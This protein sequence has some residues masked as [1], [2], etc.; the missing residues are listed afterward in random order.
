MRVDVRR[1][2]SPLLH[3]QGLADS[4]RSCCSFPSPLQPLRREVGGGP[5]KGASYVC[6]CTLDGV[7]MGMDMGMGVGS[8][9]VSCG[10][11]EFAKMPWCFCMSV[12]KATSRSQ[13]RVAPRDPS[14]KTLDGPV[15]GESKAYGGLLGLV[16]KASPGNTH[17]AKLW[18]NHGVSRHPIFRKVGTRCLAPPI[19][20]SV[21]A[22]AAR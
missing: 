16:L 15:H 19:V 18:V 4:F 17:A 10:F 20:A 13:L 6:V 14:S 5:V 1:L 11:G 7:C 21:P 3:G 9:C 22:P 2:R 8:G 12:A